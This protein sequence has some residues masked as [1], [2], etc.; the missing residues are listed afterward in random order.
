MLFEFIHL[1]IASY[2]VYNCFQYGYDNFN[3]LRSRVRTHSRSWAHI[4]VH[5]TI[6]RRP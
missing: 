1:M 3:D 5:V 2:Q 6:Y 4:L